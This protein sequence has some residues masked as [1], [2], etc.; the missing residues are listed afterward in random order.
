MAMMISGI[1]ITLLDIEHTLSQQR[2]ETA[3]DIGAPQIPEV[4]WSDIG[5]LAQA[6]QDIL[7]T[8][9]VLTF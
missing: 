8:I 2:K 1:C 6:K 7:E 5:G 9:Q 4:L 3:D